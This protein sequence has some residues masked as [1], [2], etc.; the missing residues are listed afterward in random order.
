LAVAASAIAGCPGDPTEAST[1]SGTGSAG[2]ETSVSAEGPTT[3]DDDSVSVTG[4]DSDPTDTDT[5]DPG[6]CGNR[7][8]ED[9]ETCDLGPDNTMGAMCTHECQANVCGDSYVGYSESCDPPGDGC[10]DDCILVSCGN[11][12]VDDGEECDPP[13]EGVCL[14]NCRWPEACGDGTIDPNDGED[15]EGTDLGE[16]TCSSI[17]KGFTDGMLQCDADCHFITTGCTICQ[18]GIAES[19]EQCDGSDVD[20]SSCAML[21]YVG[22]ELGCTNSCTFDDSACHNC[23]NAVLDAGEQ[24]DG[25]ALGDSDCESLGF[26]PSDML[27]CNADCTFDT[28][29]CSLCG[30]GEV[31]GTE[32]CD[33]NDF[34]GQD[35]GDFGFDSGA[36]VCTGGCQVNATMCCNSNIGDTCNNNAQCC[37]ALD[38]HTDDDVCCI[39]NGLSCQNNED[40]CCTGSCSMGGNGDCQAA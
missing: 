31:D 3:L 6:I 23:G 13:M 17:G 36:L 9:G 39:P 26:A 24:C 34:N 21:G 12:E 1:V 7:I 2:T 33:G 29:G 8:V 11:G 20:G 37:G 15:C 27:S 16:A 40:N 30:N 25:S 32:Q 18:N 35:C 19:P 10:R 5:S 4:T 14:R 22:G 28:S 38:C